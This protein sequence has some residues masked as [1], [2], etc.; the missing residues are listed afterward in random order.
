VRPSSS[1]PGRLERD[2]RMKHSGMP[3]SSSAKRP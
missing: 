2:C 1:T 3:S